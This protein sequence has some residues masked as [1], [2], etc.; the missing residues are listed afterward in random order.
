MRHVLSSLGLLTVMIAASASAQT[1]DPHAGHHPPD[2]AASSPS[3]P[4]EP[5]CPCPMMKGKDAG[6]QA[7][8]AKPSG[9]PGRMSQ[10]MDHCKDMPRPDHDAGD[11]K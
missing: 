9:A 3:P 7:D 2:S 11:G 4:A 6:M 10:D 8:G 1:A 5:P